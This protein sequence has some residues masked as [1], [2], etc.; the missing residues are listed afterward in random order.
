M[1]PITRASARRASSRDTAAT[2]TEEIGRLKVVE[3][4]VA[5]GGKKQTNLTALPVAGPAV[6]SRVPAMRAPHPIVLFKA[7]PAP[8]VEYSPLRPRQAD[9]LLSAD[10]DYDSPTTQHNKRLRREKRAQA[11]L[12]GHALYILSARIRGPLD[13]NWT[14]P[15]AT[16][17]TAD[18]MAPTAPPKKHRKKREKVID[19]TGD[20][21]IEL[22]SPIK[23][24]HER[25]KSVPSASPARIKKEKLKS[26]SKATHI[27]VSSDESD[28][29]E[30]LDTPSR[31]P[32]KRR[33]VDLRSRTSSV[34][35]R[36]VS[37]TSLAY[38][39]ASTVAPSAAKKKAI[40]DGH[41]IAVKKLTQFGKFLID[42][43][44]TQPD[45]DSPK[46]KRSTQKEQRPEIKMQ[47][48]PPQPPPK[49]P[50]PPR[51]ISS[52]FVTAA[53]TKSNE[54]PDSDV[55][56]PNVLG[57]KAKELKHQLNRMKRELMDMDIATD[58][59]AETLLGQMK[60]A[61]SHLRQILQM[62]L[63]EE[64]LRQ[65]ATPKKRSAPEVETSTRETTVAKKRKTTRE[66][67]ASKLRLPLG[68]I[69]L[70]S[71]RTRR[72]RPCP[73]PS[74]SGTE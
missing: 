62:F 37:G 42:H 20:S 40:D 12:K 47:Q 51:R 67:S 8:P 1:S 69:M 45:P 46:N 23:K 5:D 31:R 74:D 35:P 39:R 65:M 61:T 60:D 25:A 43:A 71:S 73:G 2:A 19:L 38:K 18:E 33:A 24:R 44:E 41:P 4:A 58:A 56:V 3:S 17:R 7:T 14:N 68:L 15:W 34:A 26:S 9:V 72:T 48:P 21:D 22:L 36:T 52:P 59:N 54:V 53:V 66:P 27:T 70:T 30:L 50:L 10:S 32:Q 28:I 11:Y 16:K 6:Q 29:E 63:D 13:L 57:I 64:A 55:E 49:Q